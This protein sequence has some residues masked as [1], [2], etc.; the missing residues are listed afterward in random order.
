MSEALDAADKNLADILAG[1]AES[2]ARYPRSA[3]RRY[4]TSMQ[5]RDGLRLATDVYLPDGATKVPIIVMRTPYGRRL[6]VLETLLWKLAEHGYAAVSQDCRGTGESEPDAWD[7]YIYEQEDSWDCVEWLTRQ[8]FYDGFIGGTGASYLAG[9]QWAMALHPQ[10]SGIAPEVGGLGGIKKG[11]NLHMG[12][13]AY[14]GLVGSRLPSFA[15]MAEVERAAHAE[16]LKTGFYD[17]PVDP[18]LPAMLLDRF[19]QLQSRSLSAAR[20]W[21]WD[22]YSAAPPRERAELLRQVT[23]ADEVTLGNLEKLPPVLGHS[24]HLDRHLTPVATNEA[25]FDGLRAPTL[26]ITG[27]YDWGLDITVETWGLLARHARPDVQQ[28]CR[29]L[30]TPNSHAW[31][32][33]HEGDD[34][35][36]KRTFREVENLELLLRWY[37]SLR[38]EEGMETLPPVTYYLMGGGGW[39]VAED[40]PPPGA[41]ETH[42]HLAAG[43]RLTVAP[44]DES[45]PDT[46]TYDPDDPTP[47]VG[48]SICSFTL[49]PGSADVSEVQGRDDVLVFTGE[50]LDT[51]LS[52]VGPL[53]LVLYASS[54]ALDTDFV[55][56]LS[57]VFPDG[58]A[59]CLQNGV[60]R[61]RLRDPDNPAALEPGRVYRFEIDMW[62]TANRFA[63]GHRFRVDISSADFPRFDRNT[64]GAGAGHGVVKALQTIYHDPERPSHLVFSVLDG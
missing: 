60:V 26:M 47:T 45:E 16:D 27:W 54:S 18:P 1:T 46:Y 41:R 43:G 28:R 23:E 33:Y 35:V 61:A 57:D 15:E 12:M 62:A 11:P 36:L 58:R 29:L 13:N 51:D 38:G 17:A 31:P 42:L 37:G 25:L 20:S 7:C 39:Q 52:V 4:T 2:V 44:P 6:D 21:L 64:N 8:P 53:R 48:G 34:P 22:Y 63:A 59:I 30:I 32:G 14:H 56:R 19:P 9:T 24:L 40:W 49:R 10:M 3:I 5:T 55:A 50:P